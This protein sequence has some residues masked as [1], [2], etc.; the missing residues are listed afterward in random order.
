MASIEAGSC[1]LP[2]ITGNIYGLIDSVQNGVNGLLHKPGDINTM[3]NLITKLILNRNLILEYGHNGR[4]MVKEKYL[5]KDV[6][7]LFI[8]LKIFSKI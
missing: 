8:L 7:F 6:T 1:G 4:Q 5:Q 3:E 2:V